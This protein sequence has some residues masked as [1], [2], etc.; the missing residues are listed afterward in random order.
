MQSLIPLEKIED[1]ILLIRGQ[2]VMLDRDLA[3]LYSVETKVLNQ[4]VKRSKERFPKEFMFQLNKK[5]ADN[6]LLQVMN[7]SLRSQF[8]TLKRG[9]HR[10]YLPYAFTEY[11]VVM[12]SSVLK[13][14]KAIAININ[15]IKAFI[16]LRELAFSYK[17]LARKLWELEDKYSGHDKKIKEI[18]TALHGLANKP[19]EIQNTKEIG[20]QCKKK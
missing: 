10:K 18:F 13:S 9:Q 8:V 2:K 11:G 14:Q 12:L 19:P 1:K 4:A 17:D 5:E 3:Q 20:F 7:A 15:I 6:V 16:R